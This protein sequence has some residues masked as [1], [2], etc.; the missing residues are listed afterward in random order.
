MFY[1]V[2]MIPLFSP[3]C[4][5]LS[6]FKSSLNRVQLKIYHVLEATSYL[7]DFGKLAHSCLIARSIFPLTWAGQEP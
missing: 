4:S 3:N 7:S 1:Y 5:R 6:G 2:L